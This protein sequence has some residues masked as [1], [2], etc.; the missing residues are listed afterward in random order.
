MLKKL[1]SYL[2]I[3]LTIV[4]ILNGRAFDI[5]AEPNSGSITIDIIHQEDVDGNRID[6]PIPGIKFDVYQ[7]WTYIDF[8]H[9]IF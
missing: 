1:I 8:H 4:T 2:L 9:H 5:E 6:T 3:I 7:V